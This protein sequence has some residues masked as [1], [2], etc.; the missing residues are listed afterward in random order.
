MRRT[1]VVLLNIA[2]VAV[3]G[4]VAKD[5]EHDGLAT[6]QL[7]AVGC[8][9][10]HRINLSLSRRVHVGVSPLPH[11]TGYVERP[12]LICHVAP[13]GFQFPTEQVDGILTRGEESCLHSFHFL[14]GAASIRSRQ[15][16]QTFHQWKSIYSSVLLLQLQLD[17][18]EN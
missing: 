9:S 7:D 3:D 4:R 10:L 11:S 16:E 13:A 12:Q 17:F 2:Y 1:Q 6:L 18:R 8:V 5:D 15:M 14:M